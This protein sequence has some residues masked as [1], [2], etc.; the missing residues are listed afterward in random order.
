MYSCYIDKNLLKSS[1]GEVKKCIFLR[2][3][4]VGTNKKSNYVL[5]RGG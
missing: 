3:G 2:N 1:L 5:C 4:S